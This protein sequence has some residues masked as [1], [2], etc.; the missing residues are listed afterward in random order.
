[1]SGI[2]REMNQEV[3]H[4]RKKETRSKK[5]SPS[6]YSERT[7]H[8]VLSLLSFMRKQTRNKSEI[9]LS[10]EPGIA[11]SDTTPDTD[12]SNALS[13]FSGFTL[14]K[15][16]MTS[17]LQ[18]RRESP[19]KNQLSI[20]EEHKRY[21]DSTQSGPE[22]TIASFLSVLSK[23]LHDLSCLRDLLTSPREGD[24]YCPRDLN[25]HDSRHRNLNPAWL[26][27]TS[28]QLSFDEDRVLHENERLDSPPCTIDQNPKDD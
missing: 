19:E 7:S 6:N 15:F 3:R 2:L 10:E 13:Y 25:S 8:S 26:P 27:I 28:G 11:S 20:L 12:R 22:Q 16:D 24:V 9:H 14:L 4:P 18:N 5:D 17:F 21:P 1:M 23:V